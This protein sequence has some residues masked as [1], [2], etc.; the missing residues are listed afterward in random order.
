LHDTGIYSW[1][2][3]YELGVEREK[4]R[5]QK[6]HRRGSVVRRCD[7]FRR[8]LSARAR[9]FAGDDARA[10]RSRQDRRG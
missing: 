4:R 10:H 3:L 9:S 7:S 5:R 8:G 6:S 2:Y 1:S